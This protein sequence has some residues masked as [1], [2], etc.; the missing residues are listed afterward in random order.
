MTALFVGNRP[1]KMPE[2]YRFHRCFPAVKRY[3]IGEAG[4]ER[5]ENAGFAVVFGVREDMSFSQQLFVLFL[6]MFLEPSGD[7]FMEHRP[8]VRN[9][10]LQHQPSGKILRRDHIYLCAFP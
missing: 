8:F 7:M 6:H 1:R 5:A 3:V 2:K 4:F 10:I 9:Q